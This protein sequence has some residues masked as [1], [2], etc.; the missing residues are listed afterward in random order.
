MHPSICIVGGPG[1][2]ERDPR[3]PPAQ[4][5]SIVFCLCSPAVLLP[6][7]TT[8]H[9]AAPRAPRSPDHLCPTTVTNARHGPGTS[10]HP[11]Q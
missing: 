6:I 2:M 5:G 10:P 7:A 9:A 11:S 4:W 3:T 1:Q 8:A